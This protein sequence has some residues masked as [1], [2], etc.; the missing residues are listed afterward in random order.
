MKF[1]SMKLSKKQKKAGMEVPTTAS[2][3]DGPD[4]PW[5]LEI[6]LEK[7]SL[8]KLNLGATSFKIGETG[9]IH[10]KYEVTRLSETASSEGS[11]A[12]SVNLQLTDLALEKKSLKSKVKGWQGLQN[13]EPGG[14]A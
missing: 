13:S 8:E 6:N 12:S 1:T 4:Y 5:G 7:D 2:G 10:A 11:G 3:S 9:M 14:K